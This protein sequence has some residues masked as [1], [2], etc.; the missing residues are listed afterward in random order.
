[1][2]KSLGAKTIGVVPYFLFHGVLIDRIRSQA[3][4][5]SKNSGVPVTTTPAFG[6]DERLISAIDLRVRQ[7]V[8]GSAMSSCDLC[9]YRDSSL[10]VAR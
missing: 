2:L 7:A 5:W 4:E 6:P 10:S 9:C 8:D 1:M 3:Q